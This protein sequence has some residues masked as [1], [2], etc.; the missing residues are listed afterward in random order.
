MVLKKN[1]LMIIVKLCIL[2]TLFTTV[3]LFN[4]H[5]THASSI[6][7]LTVTEELGI[8]GVAEISLE[9]NPGTGRIFIE[10]NVLTNRDT[11][12]SIR[13]A[14]QIVCSNYEFDCNNKDFFYTINANTPYVAGPSGGAGF[15]LLTYAHLSGRTI[16][17]RMSITGTI[18]SGGFVGN[19]G[20]VLEKVQA[21]GQTGIR[22]VYIPIGNQMSIPTRTLQTIRISANETN[23]TVENSNGSQD[24]T[25]NNDTTN[26][27]DNNTTESTTN[28]LEAFE[29]DA[30]ILG[31]RIGVNVIPVGTLDDI[32]EH[33]FSI[34]QEQLEIEVPEFYTNTMIAIAENIC[35]RSEDLQHEIQDIITNISRINQERQLE[36]AREQLE[37]ANRTLT[38]GD[39]YSS[40][41]FCFSAG[42]RLQLIRMLNQDIN[43]SIEETRAILEQAQAVQRTEIKTLNDLQIFTIVQERINDAET[44][45]NNALAMNESERKIDTLAYAHERAFTAISWAKFYETTTDTITINPS[46]LGP[47]CYAV[48]Q[49]AK[50]RIAYV[51]NFW[52][53]AEI[54][55][56]EQAEL[57]QRLRNY[58]MCIHYALHAKA[59]ADTISSVVGIRDPSILINT[60]QR[61][62]EQIIARQAQKGQFPILGFSYFEYGINLQDRDPISTLLY[63]QRAQ[64]QSNLD[65]YFET[66]QTSTQK[67]PTLLDHFYII[68]PAAIS[69]MFLLW[70]I[71]RK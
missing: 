29:Q 22:T 2:T 60:K 64:E 3:V 42:L 50:D 48:V 31:E 66:S 26:N 12:Q 33:A 46:D 4:T 47:A 21:A 41:S 15:A 11:Q 9:T 24:N 25:E 68:L 43:T 67:G 51:E 6:T 69:S 38:Q 36:N 56:I 37:L 14:K 30:V 32:L 59:Q 52:P 10:A 27:N 70:I 7:L 53:L 23:T 34:R 58:P 54:S 61:I 16:P 18:N 19:V 35:L 49:Q 1:T 13:F 40:A 28:P 45:F 8:G 39:Y 71:N 63:F 57:N 20:G 44:N 55:E 65:I 17:R 62:T 5:E